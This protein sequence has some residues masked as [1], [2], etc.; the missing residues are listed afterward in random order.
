MSLSRKQ[1]A[2]V[3]KE[4]DA[5]Q[6][7]FLSEVENINLLKNEI[8]DLM[9][10]KKEL[11][12]QIK[13]LKHDYDI[14]RDTLKTCYEDNENLN[15]EVYEMINKYYRVRDEKELAVNACRK[16]RGTIQGLKKENE[17]LKNNLDSLLIS[18]SNNDEALKKATESNS[19]LAGK[20]EAYEKA[21]NNK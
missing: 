13:G 1:Y 8:N 16:L 7:K 14:I 2:K 17:M 12:V 9:Q 6:K 18:Y 21:F 4:R 11:E 20:V 19:Y 5:F 3:K 15:N 10:D